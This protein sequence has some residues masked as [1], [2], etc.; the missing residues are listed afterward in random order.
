MRGRQPQA[1]PAQRAA[2]EEA[3]VRE[4][5]TAVA[6]SR[7]LPQAAAGSPFKRKEQ[8]QQNG[9]QSAHGSLTFRGSS[10]HLLT[11]GPSPQSGNDFQHP[12]FSWY[13][14]FVPPLCLFWQEV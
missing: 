5:V 11:P 4:G 8:W 13:H 2:W 1:P 7:R 6:E 14:C 10:C 9:H 3:R 12:T